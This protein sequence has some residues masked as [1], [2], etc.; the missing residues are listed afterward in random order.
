MHGKVSNDVECKLGG[1][2]VWKRGADQ[3]DSDKTFVRQPL[4]QGKPKA[5]CGGGPSLVTVNPVDAKK[6]F[7]SAIAVLRACKVLGY[8][9]LDLGR[10]L[11]QLF[12][13]WLNSEKRERE[14]EI[15]SCVMLYI[16]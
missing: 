12:S 15:W 5:F 14:R 1:G 7:F 10:L 8:T 13:Q 6:N 3:A 2:N 9:R 11:I 4:Q 16:I